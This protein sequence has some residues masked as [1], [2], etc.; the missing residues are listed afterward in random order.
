MR[1]PSLSHIASSPAL[2]GNVS[3]CP[4]REH[5]L[6][7]DEESGSE[8]LPANSLPLHPEILSPYQEV[9]TLTVAGGFDLDGQLLAPPRTIPI[10][11]NIHPRPAINIQRFYDSSPSMT[12]DEDDATHSS[13]IS[14]SEALSPSLPAYISED[15][16]EAMLSSSGS[17]DSLPSLISLSDDEVYFS[18]G[19]SD[20]LHSISLSNS[21]GS[22]DE[23]MNSE[24][25]ESQSNA[26]EIDSLFDEL[27]DSDSDFD[28]D[29]ATSIALRAGYIAPTSGSIEYRRQ[30]ILDWLELPFESANQICP[31]RIMGGLVA[32]LRW[33]AKEALTLSLSIC[34]FSILP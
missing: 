24:D 13:S 3:G 6:A 15:G 17:E 20:I 22:S 34:G 33:L 23:S 32:A 5:D 8:P 9:A 25:L 14:D 11:V 4:P 31:F 10:I 16:S 18:L 26:Q 7:S 30:Y 12:S 21:E 2:L 27:S 19:G 29:P 28:Y 1:N